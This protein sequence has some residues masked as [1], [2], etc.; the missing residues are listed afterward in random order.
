MTNETQQSDQTTPT[1]KQRFVDGYED[2]AQ[3]TKE[4]LEQAEEKSEHAFENALEK[5]KQ[6]LVDAGEFT[7]KE[8]EDLR[9]YLRRDLETTESD[10]RRWSE[11]AQKALNPSRVGTG[12][13]NLVSSLVDET[14]GVLG[15]LG[16]K[17][18]DALTYHTGE[19]TGPGTLTCTKCGKEMHRE[20]SGHIPPCSGCKG[21]TF[22]K[23]Y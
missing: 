12:F 2:L 15:K 4:F 7:K 8:A 11:Q 18:N 23:H 1:A 20:N 13:L 21:T 19:I 6:M 17:V 3:K 9:D 22:R 14:S 10:L 5:A 16:E